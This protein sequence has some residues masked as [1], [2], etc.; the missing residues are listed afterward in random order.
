MILFSQFV[1]GEPRTK[2]NHGRIIKKNGKT[3]VIP[4]EQFTVYERECMFRLRKIPEPIDSPINVK[5]VY[6]M[7]THRIVDLVGLLQ[8]TDD[9]L[10]D[11]G[12]IKDDNSRIIKSHDGSR[13][14]YDP[15]YPGVDIEISEFEHQNWVPCNESPA[16]GFYIIMKRFKGA[17]FVGIAYWNGKKWTEE[18]NEEVHPDYWHKIPK[19]IPE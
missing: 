6:H 5:C 2:K 4:S 3:S 18:N 15:D 8:A 14:V 7:A 13:V 17:E 19:F 16:N 12:I 1:S 11:A 10:T 9:I